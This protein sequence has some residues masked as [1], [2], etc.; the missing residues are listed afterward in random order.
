MNQQNSNNRAMQGTPQAGMPMNGMGG[1]QRGLVYID[2]NGYPVPTSY[3]PPRSMM[4]FGQNQ[5]QQNNMGFDDM[6]TNQNQQFNM[7]QQAP[8]VGRYVNTNADILPNEVPMDGRI[9]LF[10]LADLTEINLK[11]WSHEG[12]IKTIRYIVDPNQDPDEQAQNQTFNDIY[13]RLD[14]LEKQL[15]GQPKTSK[16]T[17]TTKEEEK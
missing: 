11:Y 12:K 4:M 7:A 8:F 1:P 14:A 5:N 17:K 3:I 10:P 13:S 16:S 15:T 9:G 2:Q 6:Q